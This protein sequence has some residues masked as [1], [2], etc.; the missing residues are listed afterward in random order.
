MAEY[1][2][3]E[4]AFVNVRL[5]HILVM[6]ELLRESSINEK[7]YLRR[8]YAEHAVNFDETLRFLDQLGGVCDRGAEVEID[9]TILGCCSRPAALSA[10]LMRRAAWNGSPFRS[11]LY[12]YLSR[13]GV[14]EEG[15]VCRPSA[16]D[17]SSQSDLRNLLMEMAIVSHEAADGA[18]VLNPGYYGLFRQVL[19]NE[20]NVRPHVVQMRR[21][22]KDAIGASAEEA[23]MSF[24][25]QRVGPKFA[26]HVE[27]IALVDASAGFDI[28]SIT[29]A[30]TGTLPRFVEVKAVPRGSLR[31]YWTANEIATA[32]RFGSWYFL[33][34]VP[35]VSTGK[36]DLEGLHMV[37]DPCRVLFGG[38]DWIATP[39]T[40]KCE[41]ACD[42][43]WD[44]R[45]FI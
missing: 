28:A 31:F 45:E 10:E 15:L 16:Q 29:I 44:R 33:Y 17:R 23:V 40:Y 24:E 3:N 25:R 38:A 6:L 14:A 8:R 4:T 34:L 18:Y 7:A 22:E 36:F 41:L 12:S 2:E 32:R 19:L 11:E 5:A 43:P 9:P 21:A 27:H 35:V 20:S 37:S 30:D 26:E 1:S 13:F 39:E 42:V